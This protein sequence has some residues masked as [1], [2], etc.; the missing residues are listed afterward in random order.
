MLASAVLR[1]AA[2]EVAVWRRPPGP[3]CGEPLPASLLK[4]ADE[5]TLTALAVVGRAVAAADP[6]TTRFQE[7]GVLAAPR[8]PGRATVRPSMQ[9]YHAEGA[10]GVSPHLI[11]HRSLHTISGALSQA[12][13]CHG[14]NYGVGGGPDHVSDGLLAAVTLLH[15][16]RLPG[17][18]LVLTRIEPELPTGATLDVHP[19]AW[20]EALALA[21]VP[22]GGATT[23]HRLEVTPDRGAE[24]QAP[25]SFAALA[26]LFAGEG[27]VSAVQGSLAKGLR[28]ELRRHPCGGGRPPVPLP[29]SRPL[30]ASP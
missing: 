10:W 27:N 2:P 4:H 29:S 25:L 14:P 1:V 9:R 23:T 18:W 7:W 5:Q 3:A 28:L 17:L 6:G 22:L 21:L 26:D 19:A 11:P 8:F 20:C 24:L 13:S 15:G 16:A 12:L 30:T